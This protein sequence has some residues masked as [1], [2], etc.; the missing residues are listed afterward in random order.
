MAGRPAS[1]TNFLLP[2]K[3]SRALDNNISSNYQQSRWSTSVV[4]AALMVDLERDTFIQQWNVYGLP[5][6]GWDENYNLKSYSLQGSLDNIAW[7]SYDAVDNND[8]SYTSRRLSN[9]VKVRF[10]R[11]VVSQGFMCNLKMAS[12]VEFQVYEADTTPNGLSGLSVSDNNSQEV[13]YTPTFSAS[14]LQYSA[15]IADTVSSVTIT[16]TAQDEQAIITVNGTKVKSGAASTSITLANKIT[17]IS[18]V[19]TPYRGNAKTYKITLVKPISTKLTNLV[20]KDTSGNN[21]SVTP[22][23]SKDITSYEVDIPYDTTITGVNLIPTVEDTNASITVNST[24]VAS[25]SAY[26]PVVVPAYGNKTEVPFVVAATG[27]VST[28]YNVSV[29]R[30]SSP[31]LQSIKASGGLVTPGFKPNLLDYKMTTKYASVTLTAT[32]VDLGAAVILLLKGQSYASGDSIPVDIGDNDIRIQ[33]TS[34]I[35][36]DICNYNIKVT[37]NS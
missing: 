27:T 12:V 2:Y 6:I 9:P 19:V 34:A 15:N 25:G 4:P 21:L 8:S 29:V 30:A 31:Y 7:F 36:K 18:V 26:G 37:R 33:V 35:G 32:P 28:T 17:V 14:V 10:V 16:P 23:F 20:A 24:P 11:L 1:A 5:S 22:A 3:P 13:A